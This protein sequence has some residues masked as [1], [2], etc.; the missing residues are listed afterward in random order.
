MKSW[1]MLAASVAS[2]KYVS[3][4]RFNANR[5]IDSRSLLGV[6]H[7]YCDDIPDGGNFARYHQLETNENDDVI[8]GLF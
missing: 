3:S 6:V 4:C 8:M 7:G 5:V 1:M 2:W